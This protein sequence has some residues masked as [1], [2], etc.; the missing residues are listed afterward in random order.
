MVLTVG[1]AIG[2]AQYGWWRYMSVSAH[3]ATATG[4]VLTT[5]CRNNND[6]SYSFET[7]GRVLE[8]RD[9]W[10]ECRSLKAGD[11][12]PISFSSR[13]PS[14][15]MI[16]DAHARL[17]AESISIVIASILGSIVVAIAFMAP[18]R[19]QKT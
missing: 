1:T 10:L 7:A 13:D 16:G 17:I 3:Q 6:V 11:T 12:L 18:F 14:R 5:N 4:T 2:A 9:N 8:G 19:K 15:N